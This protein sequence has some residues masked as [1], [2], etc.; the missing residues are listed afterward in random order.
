MRRPLEAAADE[1]RWNKWVNAE[2]RRLQYP[3][4][5]SHSMVRQ[6]AIWLN[7]YLVQGVEHADDYADRDGTEPRV[8]AGPGMMDQWRRH[9]DS[10]LD[11]IGKQGE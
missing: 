11:S 9:W 5:D 2:E 3:E 1:W 10:T 8:A 7:A 6:T 4:G